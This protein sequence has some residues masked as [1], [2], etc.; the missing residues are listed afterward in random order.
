[1]NRST[2]AAIATPIGSAG[3][4]IIRISGLGAFSIASSVFRKSISGSAATTAF[5]SQPVAAFQSHHLYHGYIVDPDSERILDEVLL[6]VMRLPHSYT[7]E[8]I[9]EINSH[10]GSIILRNILNLTLK[11]GARLAEPGEFTKRA[12]INGR[13]D[14]TQAESVMDIITARSDKALEIAATHLGG[15]LKA[16]IEHIREFLLQILTEMEAAID[17]PEDSRE[18][19]GPDK[20]IAAIENHALVPLQS[21]VEQYFNAHIFRDGLVLAVVGKPNVG[22]SSLMNRLIQKDRVIVSAIPGTTRDFIEEAAN[23][24]GI[25]IV[26]ADTAG[27]HET[28]DPVEVMGIKKTREYID[29]ADLILFVIDASHSLTDAD[30]HI[31]ETIKEKK[32][33]LVL[34]KSDLVKNDFHLDKPDSWNKIPASTIS[35]LYDRGIDQLRNLIAM[36]SMDD[37]KLDVHDTIVPNVRHKSLL[38]RSLEAV[39]SAVS[40]LHSQTP[41]ELITIDIQQALTS[42]GEIIGMTVKEDVLDQIFSRFCIGK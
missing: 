18:V 39:T 30:Y 8:D 41:V 7:R 34:N 35:A 20:I 17:F 1:M 28:D 23:I 4:G 38:D 22:K 3:I 33:L 11:M 42:L 37:F 14:L 16:Q 26:I 12:F 15:K 9:V 31:Y 19:V 2:I 29:S 13:I 10:S 21:L 24:H 36:V 6:S 27:L 25:P 32:A 5:S 40:S